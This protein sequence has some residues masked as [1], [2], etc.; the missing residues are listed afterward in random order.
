MIVARAV[1]FKAEDIALKYLR[2]RGFSIV[3]KNIC[4]PFGEIDI[5]A[6]QGETLV[7]V[8]VKYRKNSDFGLPFEY[9]TKAKQRKIILAAQAYLNRKKLGD[10]ACR[11]DVLSMTGDLTAPEIEH[12]S[13]AFWQESY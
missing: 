9:V 11:F 6:K 1:G 2:D 3:D 12:L 8:E 7:F 10:V 5:V 13:D 4:F